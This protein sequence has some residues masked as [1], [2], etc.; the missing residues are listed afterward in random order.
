MA[1]EESKVP[2]PSDPPTAASDPLEGDLS[3]AE[4]AEQDEAAV[5]A[6]AAAAEAKEYLM[7]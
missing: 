2:K 3:A 7:L 6:A 1:D 4:D 5:A